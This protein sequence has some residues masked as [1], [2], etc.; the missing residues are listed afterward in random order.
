MIDKWHLA[1]ILDV[2]SRMERVSL[3]IEVEDRCSILIKVPSPEA[4]SLLGPGLI[5][6]R[7]G[8]WP[9]A[10]APIL[11][12]AFQIKPDDM[13]PAFQDVLFFDVSR[14]DFWNLFY[15]LCYQDELTFYFIDNQLNPMGFRFIEW[16]EIQRETALKM[17]AQ[18]MVCLED[19]PPGLYDFEAAKVAFQAKHS[20]DEILEVE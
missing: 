3:A 13:A 10:T 4:L 20:L 16:D 5:R 6:H 17:L 9:E 8:Y 15:S 7:L 12:L 2:I 14:R 11:C 1:A 19:I 18:A